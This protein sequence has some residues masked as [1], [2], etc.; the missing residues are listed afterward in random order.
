MLRLCL[1]YQHL[2]ASTKRTLRNNIYSAVLSSNMYG[3]DLNFF[4]SEPGKK[5]NEWFSKHFIVYNIYLI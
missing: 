1:N 2:F 5:L 4:T 3:H